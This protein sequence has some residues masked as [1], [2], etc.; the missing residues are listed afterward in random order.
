MREA[1]A[2]FADVGGLTDGAVI[3]ADRGAVLPDAAL[4]NDAGMLCQSGGVTG[5]ACAPDG[6]GISGAVVEAATVDCAGSP[7][8]R[9][10]ETDA[11]GR[12]RLGDLAPG[13]IEIVIRSGS[14]RN[15][16]EVNVL[17]GVDVF[18]SG[19]V[20]DKICLDSDSA[21]LAVMT[22]NYDRI[23]GVLD[24]LGFG[25]DLVCGGAADHRHAR[26]LIA[27]FD[28]LTG[29]DILFFNCS[30]GIDFSATNPE[31]E[32][33][34]GNLQRFVQQGGS[35]YVSDLA[36]GVIQANWPGFIDFE[37]VV[38]EPAQQQPCCVC[39]DCAPGCREPG[40]ATTCAPENELPA[41]CFSG[42]GFSG[43]GMSGEV[44]GELAA[45]FLRDAVGADAVDLVFNASGW[46][47][48][49]SVSAEV[50][51]LVTDSDGAP[52]MVLFQPYPAGGR[53]AFTSF[54]NHTQATAE[55]RAILAA[56]V[57]R[58]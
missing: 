27:D 20:S 11:R 16:T 49:R 30:S 18:A 37:A 46:V 23:E 17:A 57:L 6:T 25:Y 21:R 10:T 29:R 47:E 4:F 7:V 45:G 39:T 41:S 2:G 56:L 14:F 3:R 33:L 44:R 13:P 51:V 52:L 5:V 53:I 36:A 42:G 26:Q 34:R 58:L 28:Q 22:G 48:M 8:I 31:V 40:N 9:R 12:F 55:M 32:Q 24:G 15:R 54:H 1:G 43:R 38:R 50:E 19:D 35:L